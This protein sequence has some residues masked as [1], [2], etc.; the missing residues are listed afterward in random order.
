VIDNLL[1]TVRAEYQRVVM[2]TICAVII[3]ACALVATLFVAVAVFI[4]MSDHYGTVAAALA[5]AAFFAAVALTAWGVLAYNAS[6]AR[7]RE[8]ERLEQEKRERE[9][10][11][12]H[13]PPAWLDPALL[14]SMLPIGMQAARVAMRHRGLLLALISSIAVGWGALREGRKP[15]AG[16]TAEQPAE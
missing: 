10:A 1:A 3:A 12:K 16:E 9:E 8:K 4:W 15:P 13:A 6:V 5:M 14:A 11:A 7:E 2:T